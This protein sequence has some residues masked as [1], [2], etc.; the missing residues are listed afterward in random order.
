MQVDV[1]SLN[2][3]LADLT[4]HLCATQLNRAAGSQALGQIAILLDL[5]IDALLKDVEF[6]ALRHGE[7]HGELFETAVAGEG[8]GV[9]LH[10]ELSAAFSV[11]H[12][13][14]GDGMMR[15]DIRNVYEKYSEFY[16]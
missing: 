6:H 13:L 16:Q 12:V 14:C 1:I 11:A 8:D 4:R 2:E 9:V 10:V 7:R 15:H 3:Q 5:L